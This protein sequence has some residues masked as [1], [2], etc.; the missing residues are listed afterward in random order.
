MGS[1]QGYAGFCNRSGAGSSDL[2]TPY[3]TRAFCRSRSCRMTCLG[4]TGSFAMESCIHWF[5]CSLLPRYVRMCN[6]VL[7]P[8][9]ESQIYSSNY[10]NNHRVSTLVSNIYNHN[11]C[12]ISYIAIL[13][14][15][16]LSKQTYL[17]PKTMTERN[18][19][20][21]RFSKE[22]HYS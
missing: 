6:S 19:P 3:L 5:I 13:L 15:M 17:P 1:L 2:S 8:G 16:C 9:Q 11:T 14:N 21:P 20:S 22:R 4:K 10:K 12:H 7:I 18:I